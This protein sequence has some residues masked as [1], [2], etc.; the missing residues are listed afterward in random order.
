MS[1]RRSTTTLLACCAGLAVTVQGD[2]QSRTRPMV[3][4]P[5]GAAAE[6]SDATHSP[7]FF[8][9][10][11]DRSVDQLPLKATSAKV[12]IAGVIADVKVTQVYRNTGTKALEA[13]YVFPGSTRSAVY[14]MTMTV[15]GRVLKAKIKEREQARADYEQAKQQGRSA[16]LLEQH[17]PNVFQMNVANI[18]PGDEIR[19]ELSYTELLVPTEGTYAFV[20]PTVVGPRYAGRAGTASSTG[21]AWVANPYTHAGEKPET[22]L[23]LEL[24]LS[25]GMAIQRMACDT[26]KTSIT[27]DGKA[28]ATLRLDPSEAHGG[29]RDVIVRYQLAGGGVQSGLLLN[30]GKEENTFLLMAQPPKR[31]TPKDLPPREY[32]FIMD[33]SGSQ[34]G[35]PIEVSKVLMKEMIQGLRPQDLFNVMVFEGSSALWS[36]SGS[37]HATPENTQQALAFVRS[38]NGGGGT[39]LNAAMQRALGLPR[40]P[41][42]SRTF[43]VSTDGYISADAQVF[44]TIRKNLGAANLFTFGIGSSVNRHLVEGMARAGQG[45]AFVITRPE[46]AAAEAERFRAY[47]SSPVLTN[48]KL[49]SNGFRMQDLEPIQLP[50]VLADR[51]VI[52]LGR[53]TGEAK[54]TVTLSG[55]SGSGP[56]SQTFE[57]GQVKGRDHGALR[58]LWARQRVQRL[59]DDDQFGQEAGRK[60][61]ITSL[62][63]TYN[64][65]TAY[66][67]FVAVDTVVRQGGASTTVTQPLPMPEGV[68]DAAV[69]GAMRSVAYAPAPMVKMMGNAAPASAAAEMLA[70]DRVVREEKAKRTTEPRIRAFSGITGSSD[71]PS[72]R[73]ELSARLKDPAL[74]AALAG[75]P[76]GT[77]LDLKVDAH[78]QILSATFRSAFPGAAKAQRLIE[79]WR[80]RTW[81]GGM[82]GEIQLTLG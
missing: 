71:L 20:Y 55:I 74:V 12:A 26:H 61:E 49:T 41:G 75:L 69:G 62:G 44:D 45:E 2:A 23:D 47:V 38:Q 10:G 53:W 18:L 31:V 58:Q 46:Q 52:C 3:V 35:F 66:T 16:S 54:G 73:S 42:I 13:I 9:K 78:G 48:L 70:Q 82:A 24:K 29:N 60:A 27:Y 11:D 5:A 34:M 67:S 19:V 39:E 30:Q 68:S 64:L 4:R 80:L 56:W 6:D 59:S 21:E 8:V 50:D 51:P 43:V 37:Q 76:Q 63:L 77:V 57:V 25:A 22:T 1:L 72:L 81:T 32:V 17:R 15:G 14:G 79:A 40:V 33:V 28:E 65:L 36:P 7:Y